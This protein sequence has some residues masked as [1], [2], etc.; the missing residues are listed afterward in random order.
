[1]GLAALKVVKRIALVLAVLSAAVACAGSITIENAYPSDVSG[2]PVAVELGDTFYMTAR[3]HTDYNLKG[4]YKIRFDLPYMSRTSQGFGFVGDAY[5]VWGPYPALLPGAMNVKSTILPSGDKAGPPLTI[6]I[7]PSLPGQ[8][9]EFFNAQNLSAQFGASAKLSSGSI[10]GLEWVSPVPQSGGFQN[11]LDP[12]PVTAVA[13]SPFAQP[14][15]LDAQVGS[16][17][18]QFQA[19]CSSARV[20][21]SILREVGF[22]QYAGL[23]SDIAVWLK[24][25]TLVE[26]TNADIARFVSRTLPSGFRQKMTPYDVA[27]KLFQ[28]VVAH[29]T[30]VISTAKPDALVALNS[31]RGDCG[32]FSSLFVACCRNAGIPARAAAGMLAGANQWHVWTEFYLPGYGWIPAD[33]A[34]CDTLRPDGS[35]PLYFGTIPELNQRVALSYGFDH[36]VNGNAVTVLQSPAVI[37]AAGTRVLSVQAWCNLVIG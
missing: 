15:A 24:P 4:P 10:S 30:Y 27:Q 31:A 9:I 23:D 3:L 6:Q 32:A 36:F 2:N 25:E 13:S 11:V 14:V 37:S 18:Y 7:T 22:D 20:N 19:S 5:V 17:A 29:M 8:G 16:V 21:P 34:F 35:M 28:A 26:S 1:M 12:A 33:P